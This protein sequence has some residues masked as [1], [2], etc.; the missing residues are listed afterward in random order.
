M[1]KY[2]AK[3]FLLF[4]R[5]AKYYINLVEKLGDEMRRQEDQ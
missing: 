1:I 5:F 4:V 2:I 3:F